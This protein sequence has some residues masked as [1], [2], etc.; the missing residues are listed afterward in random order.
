[1]PG[2][3]GKIF[4]EKAEDRDAGHDP[5][6]QGGGRG[7]ARAPDMNYIYVFNEKEGLFLWQFLIWQHGNSTRQKK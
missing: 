1:M 2:I 5:R 4:R 3:D 7:S 6:T